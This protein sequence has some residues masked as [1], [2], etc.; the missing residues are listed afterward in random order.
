[1][2]WNYVRNPA[3]FL[4]RTSVQAV[5]GGCFGLVL[6]SSQSLRGPSGCSEQFPPP[7]T[8]VRHA[9]SVA[10]VI[11][12]Q[13][14]AA[15]YKKSWLDD[16]ANPPEER[17]RDCVLSNAGISSTLALAGDTLELVEHDPVD[18]K[19][20]LVVSPLSRTLLTAC[21]LF[22]R[23]AHARNV[24]VVV[25]PAAMEVLNEPHDLVENLGR[26]MDQVF[27]EARSL[28]LDRDAPVGA[29]TLLERLRAAARHLDDDWWFFPTAASNIPKRVF[30]SGMDVRRE[31]LRKSLQKHVSS[32]GRVTRVF[33][34]THWGVL[35]ALNGGVESKNLDF[36]ELKNFL[37]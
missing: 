3:S 5:G 8:I 13:G 19:I 11:K 31:R 9:E 22:H 36:V 20:L 23:V 4:R 24:C 17:L 32:A 35:Y 18:G 10:N 37:E 1:M 34:V 14:L 30:E 27:D 16:S 7:V 21:L 28:L 15:Y 6:F 26:P 33:I 2:W 29:L 25:D 12:A